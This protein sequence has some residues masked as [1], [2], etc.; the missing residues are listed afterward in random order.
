MLFFCSDP[1]E[2]PV[3]LPPDT[4]LASVQERRSGVSEHGVC[5]SSSTASTPAGIWLLHPAAAV[6]TV[7]SPSGQPAALG[8]CEGL[9]HSGRLG[10]RWTWCCFFPILWLSHIASSLWVQLSLAQ[11]DLVLYL[12]ARH[13]LMVISRSRWYFVL[14]TNPT[15]LEQYHIFSLLGLHC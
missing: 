1:C 5:S 6:S 14:N 10:R 7:H 8:I 11:K 15:E 13:F 2:P 12:T 3:R 9:E 4:S